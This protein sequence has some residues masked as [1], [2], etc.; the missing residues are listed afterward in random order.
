MCECV[1]HVLYIQ[2]S[3]KEVVAGV[4]M[5]RGVPQNHWVVLCVFSGV[6]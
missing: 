5:A 6:C 2:G 4:A 3:G 1:Y